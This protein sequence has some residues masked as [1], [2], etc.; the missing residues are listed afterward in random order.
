MDLNTQK[1][2]VITSPGWRLKTDEEIEKMPVRP[3]LCGCGDVV[4]DNTPR[5][6]EWLYYPWCRNP[7]LNKNKVSTDDQIQSNSSPSSSI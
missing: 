3:W 1:N 5:K 4:D 2:I 7:N 6:H